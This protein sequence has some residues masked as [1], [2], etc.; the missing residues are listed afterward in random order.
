MKRKR[1][2]SQEISVTMESGYFDIL[3]EQEQALQENHRCL[4]SVC[5]I[6]RELAEPEKDETE[7][8]Q[9]LRLLSEKYQ[10]LVGSSI[11]LRYVKYQTRE[12][13]IAALKRTRRNGD[14]NR[15]QNIEGLSEFVTVYEKISSDYLKYVN[16]LERLSVDLVKDIE[17]ADPTVSEFVVGKWNPPKGILEILE[18]L[19]DPATDV[20]AVR[21]RL[22]GYLD[23]IK[24]ERAKYIIEN[25]HSLQGALRDLNKEVSSWR[26]EWD[27]IENVMFG[28]GSNSMKK[29]LQN[30]ESLKS[31]LQL[32]EAAD[33][34][35][36]ASAE[37][38]KSFT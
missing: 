36:M 5:K 28:D 13:E 8:V 12:S 25:K 6:L 3:C 22:D 29:M 23:R 20:S 19:A 32:E 26:K 4:D 15:L 35:E 34:L 16:L 31:K 17:I 24:M 18:E 37:V 14:Y 1:I 7:Q 21:S 2:E 11:S 27:S 38:T 9:S 33:V 30:I 10:E